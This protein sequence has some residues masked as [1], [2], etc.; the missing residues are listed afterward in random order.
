MFT[1]NKNLPGKA[2]PKAGLFAALRGKIAK[3]VGEIST[4]FGRNYKKK[5]SRKFVKK[6]VDNREKAW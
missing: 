4:A 5:K 2:P 3:E 6:V 1:S